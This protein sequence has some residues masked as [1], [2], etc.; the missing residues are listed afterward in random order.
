MDG[1]AAID[2]LPEPM[3][4]AELAPFVWLRRLHAAAW[5]SVHATR[6]PADRPEAVQR[7]TTAVAQ[8]SAGLAAA[9]RGPA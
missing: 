5:W 1:R 9:P 4:E 3:S 2:A 8:V 6:E 7:L